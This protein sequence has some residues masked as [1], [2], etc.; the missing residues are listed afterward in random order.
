MPS[1]ASP[2]LLFFLHPFTSSSWQEAATSRG[3][4]VALGVGCTSGPGFN[5]KYSFEP[6]LRMFVLDAAPSLHFIGAGSP[7]AQHPKPSLWGL[8]ARLH[9]WLSSS[10]LSEPKVL[11]LWESHVWIVFTRWCPGT[12]HCKTHLRAARSRVKAIT[13]SLDTGF[14]DT[15][16]NPHPSHCI[17]SRTPCF[18]GCTDTASVLPNSW[19]PTVLPRSAGTQLICWVS[20]SWEV[21]RTGEWRGKQII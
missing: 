18:L 4:Q 19:V 6:H 7:P 10:G 13:Q 3:E 20:P 2:P 17:P 9:P 11:S 15:E 14:P 16:G 8:L 12:Q 21:A 5:G 1:Q